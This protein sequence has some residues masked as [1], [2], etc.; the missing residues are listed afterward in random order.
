MSTHTHNGTQ[1]MSPAAIRSA[2]KAWARYQLKN[3]LA[4][5]AY[6]RLRDTIDGRYLSK[7]VTTLRPASSVRPEFGQLSSQGW[8]A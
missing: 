5:E 4:R 7:P 3:A 6:Y 2:L 1:E 8:S